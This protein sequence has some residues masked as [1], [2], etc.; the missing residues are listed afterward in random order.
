MTIPKR[1]TH[2]AGIP[3]DGD[4]ERLKKKIEDESRNKNNPQTTVINPNINPNEYIYIPSLNLYV[5]KQ[6]THLGLNWYKT[7]EA[8]H[9][10][11]LFMLTIPQFISFIK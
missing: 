9:K 1:P 3:V 5:A 11:N 2:F 8:L 4:M 6:R 7:H 10:E